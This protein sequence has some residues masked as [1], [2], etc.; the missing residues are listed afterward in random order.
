MFPLEGKAGRS[1][2]SEHAWCT[3]HVD[4]MV[5]DLTGAP[6]LPHAC[7]QSF[8]SHMCV[9][10]RNYDRAN[11]HLTAREEHAGFEQ[12][13][14]LLQ[15]DQI[16]R[17]RESEERRKSERSMV[18]A[19]EQLKVLLS[20]SLGLY[21]TAP[22]CHCSS[23]PPCLCL[24]APLCHC[25]CFYLAVPLSHCAP[26]PC[27]SISLSLYPTVLLSYCCSISLHSYLTVL[28]SH[29]ASI[30]LCL[31]ISMRPLHCA[32]TYSSLRVSHICICRSLT[33]TQLPRALPR[34]VQ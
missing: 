31:H 20:M 15:Q 33:L 11:T 13:R 26:T 30:P 10:Q 18:V 4:R 29:C 28:L 12:L 16:E 8:L 3:A 7:F 5:Q 21:A 25:T 14:L 6:S 17:R 19:L 22:L 34:I 32:N 24:T 2:N 9:S 1:W 27:A 23:M